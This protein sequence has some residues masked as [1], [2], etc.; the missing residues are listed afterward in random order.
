ME[1]ISTPAG[2]NLK[3]L[4]GGLKGLQLT[5]T[6]QMV[7]TACSVQFSHS[8][9]SDSLRPHGLQHPRP[10][11]PS[12]TPR[13]YSDA[14]SLSWWCH[15]T[16]SSSVGPFSFCP[17][18]FPASGSLPR[19]Q[20]LASDGR[21]IGASALA[22]VLPMNVQDCALGLTGLNSLLSKGLSRVF[23][24]IIIQKHQFF[25]AQHSLWSNSNVCTWLLEKP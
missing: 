24:S 3:T 20:F 18:S 23:S 11:C 6:V 4:H 25:G 10:P 8:V 2:P 15:P 14:C 9:V 17:Q 5:Y 19:S 12:P 13:V 21:S 7:S 16:I 1:K 22:S